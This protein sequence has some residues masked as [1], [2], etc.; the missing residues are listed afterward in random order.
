MRPTLLLN[1]EPETARLMLNNVTSVNSAVR[2][3]KARTSCT[4]D[5]W[6]HPCPRATSSTTLHPNRGLQFHQ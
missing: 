2:E 3:N 4:C 5:R 1:D 6:G